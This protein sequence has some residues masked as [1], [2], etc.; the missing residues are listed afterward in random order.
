[1]RRAHLLY[2][3]LVSLWMPAVIEAAYDL[4]LFSALSRRPATSEEVAAALSIHPRGARVILDA[5]FACDLVECDEP[6]GGAPIY[7]LP[8]DVKACVEPLGLFSLA[9]K[10][11]YDR[12]LAWKAWRNFATAVRE[13]AAEKESEPCRQN[14]ISPEEYRFLT[15]GINFWAPPIIHALCEGFAKIGWSTQ[16]SASILDVGCGTGIYSQLLLQRYETWRAVGLDCETMAALARAQSAEMGVESRFLCQVSDFWRYPWGTGFD[17][18]LLTN[19]FHLQ[20]PDG[21][22]RLMK[23]AGE[24]ASKDGIVC[25][26]DQIRDD[27]RHADTAQNRFALLFA[28]SMLATG[29][30]DTYT[31]AQY[32]AW[33]RDADL[34]R[35]TLLPTPM[36]RILIARRRSP[37]PRG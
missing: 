27:R 28:A 29:G 15:K 22:A 16:R 5:L 31:L 4:D 26:I 21:A 13:G 37:S 14:Q 33:L 36:H 35:I 25:I 23:L 9:G 17:L 8:E 10:M 7:R 2:E 19:I 32:D 1:M 12:R 20:T 11:L 3:Q 6:P 18:I 24:A 34:E 30:G